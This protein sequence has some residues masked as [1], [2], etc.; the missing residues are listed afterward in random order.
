MS[1]T[2]GEKIKKYRLEKGLTQE[3]LG[4]VL[5]VG[6]AAV[7]KYESNQVQN[8]KSAHIKKLCT[9]FNKIPWDFIYDGVSM[10]QEHTLEQLQTLRRIFGEDARAILLPLSEL[11]EKGLE[12]VYRYIVDMTKIEE[13]C[14][15]KNYT[16]K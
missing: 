8:L 14:K 9:L 3:E 12:K 2:V 4:K 10:E 6:K 15:P 5:G 16:G 7:Q 13:Y 11:N 1:L